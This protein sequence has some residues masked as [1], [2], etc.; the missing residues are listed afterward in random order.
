VRPEVTTSD[1][2]G[3]AGSVLTFLGGAGTVTGSKALVHEGSR[4]TLV[5]CGLFQGRRELRRRNWEPLPVSAAGISDVLLTHAHLDHTGYLPALVRQGFRGP[6]LTTRATAALTRIVLLDSAHLLEEDARHAR[7]HGYSKHQP[8][9]PLYTTADA[10]RALQQLRP[11]EY[12]AEVEVAVGTLRFGRAGHILGSA[13]AFLDLPRSGTSVLFSGDLGRSTHPLLRPPDPPGAARFVVLESTYGNRVHAEHGLDDLAAA[14]RRTVARGG[15]VLIPAFAVDRTEVVL[16]A[17]RQLTEDGRIPEVPVYVDSPMALRALD[18]YRQAVAQ[19]D[20]DVLPHLAA[21]GDPFDP[22]RLTALRTVEESRSVNAPRW[23][24]IIVS[25]SGMATGGRVLHHLEHLLPDARNS[26]L[27]V[28]FQ[29]V[30]TRARDLAEGATHLK[31]H[32]R[33]VPVR[34]EV[35]DLQSFSV[36][37]DADELLA[38]LS[39]CPSPPDACFVVHGEPD[40]SA[41]LAARIECELGWLAVVPRPGE[42]IRID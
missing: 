19:Q 14:V 29:A 18:V 10:E 13:T 8:P 22:G 21:T 30:G 6:V 34:A 39:G 33:Y 3:P 32:G 16:D 2:T 1:A 38:W 25:A 27:L 5:D 12:G 17:L 35:A 31:L 9:L 23:P 7:E 41:A 15:S 42:R 24:C 40:A 26:V 36:H 11:V 4:S 20:E 28:G 37:A